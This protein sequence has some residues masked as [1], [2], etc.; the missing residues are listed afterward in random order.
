[1]S[2]LSIEGKNFGGKGATLPEKT[3]KTPRGRNQ[4]PKEGSIKPD[5]GTNNN[6]NDHRREEAVRRV[7]HCRRYGSAR[8]GYDNC[9]GCKG[10]WNT[11]GR[12]STGPT[13]ACPILLREMS[14]RK[15]RLE[16]Y[17]IIISCFILAMMLSNIY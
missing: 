9:R 14:L 5:N 4:E 16:Q 13:G 17:N 1:M 12:G 7:E 10:G 8:A 11:C 2:L 15:Y 6:N 3:S